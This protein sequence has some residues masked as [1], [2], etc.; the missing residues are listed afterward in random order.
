MK[1]KLERAEKL[2]IT[3]AQLQVENEALRRERSQWYTEGSRNSDESTQY[4]SRISAIGGSEIPTPAQ[5]IKLISDLR[6]QNEV[7]LE[8]NVVSL[9][10]HS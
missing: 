10:S 5:A 3:S 6:K 1:Q 8:K 7:L 2:A 9:A 4:S